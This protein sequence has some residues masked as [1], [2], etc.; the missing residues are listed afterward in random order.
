MKIKE[1]FG[2]CGVKGCNNKYLATLEV[3]AS[4]N[5]KKKKKKVRVCE[6]HLMEIMEELNGEIN[7][8]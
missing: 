3:S 1:I 2:Y 7:E 8:N 4:K 6:N 5:D